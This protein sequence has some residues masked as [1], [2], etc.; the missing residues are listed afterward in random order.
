MLYSALVVGT[1]TS[2]EEFFPTIFCDTGNLFTHSWVVTF[3]TS[4]QKII[5]FRSCFVKYSLNF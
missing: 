5:S 1:F 4:C 2:S 3:L